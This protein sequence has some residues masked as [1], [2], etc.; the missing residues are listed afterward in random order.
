MCIAPPWA[1]LIAK[2]YPDV[3]DVHE[4]LWAHAALPVERWPEPHR[5]KKKGLGWWIR[6]G[7]AGLLLER[8]RFLEEYELA[9]KEL[10]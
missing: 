2:A 3:D 7:K 6:Q 8:K 4:R 5:E 10:A 9:D 1:E